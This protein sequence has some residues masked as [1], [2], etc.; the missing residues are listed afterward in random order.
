LVDTDPYL[1]GADA[2]SDAGMPDGALPD[3]ALPDGAPPTD[4]APPDAGD[5]SVDPTLPTRPGI[6][7]TPETP[8]TLD[9]LV[10]EITME[11]TD[12][13][14]TGPVTYEWAWSRDGA[15]VS[16]TGD[17]ISADLTSKAE[18]WRVGIT[19]V[20]SDGR[21]GPPGTLE[22]LIRNSLPQLAS[23]R[24]SSYRPVLGESLRAVAG[25]P[26]DADGDALGYTYAWYQNDVL[27][28]GATGASL[29][30]SMFGIASDDEIRVEVTVRDAE[31]DGNTVAVG[32]ALVLSDVTRWRQLLP[33]RT[34]DEPNIAFHDSLNERVIYVYNE[35]D[36]SDTRTGVWE[37]ALDGTDSWTQLF[38]S[39]APP[40]FFFPA[41]VEDVDNERILFF[42][43]GVL[44]ATPFRAPIFQLDVSTR[45][46]EAWTELPTIGTPPPRYLATYAL[47]RERNRIFM[48]GGADPTT[49]P[50]PTVLN[51]LWSLDI[52]TAG[53]EAWTRHDVGL[54]PE[55]IVGPGFVVDEARDRLMMISGGTW[56]GDGEPVASSTLFTLDL[57]DLST[58]FLAVS[59]TVSTPRYLGTGYV[60]V[61]R[62]RAL[63]ANGI[64]DDTPVES[65]IEVDL[66][67][68][69][70]TEVTPD[71]PTA[72]AVT[73][74]NGFFASSAA[75][76]L[77]YP[78]R[79]V[80][81]DAMRFAVYRVDPTSN[82][83]TGVHVTGVD[84]PGSAE[85]AMVSGRRELFLYGGRDVDRDALDT[86]WEID[87]LDARF[88]R[89]PTLADVADSMSP[90]PRFGHSFAL[91]SPFGSDDLYFMGGL[92][93]SGTR[94]TDNET[95][96]L[97]PD[98]GQWVHRLLAASSIRPPIA[99]GSAYYDPACGG[100][101]TGFFGGITDAGFS[102]QAYEFECGD[103]ERACEWNLVQ[104]QPGDSGYTPPPP[105]RAWATA[106]RLS[107]LTRVLLFGG[108]FG[109]TSLNDVHV[110]NPC[111]SSTQWQ[112]A[113]TTGT[114]PGER[115]GHS[116]VVAE[117]DFGSSEPER[118]LIFGGS[119]SSESLSDAFL[120]TV[121]GTAG[122]GTYR[123]SPVTPASGP[124]DDHISA[125]RHHAAYWD[126]NEQ[127]MVVYGGSQNGA[128]SDMWVLLLRP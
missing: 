34:A 39:G 114:P 45:G 59:A 91:S 3:G 13:M 120:L 84:L 46:A 16:E 64:A 121:E 107:D 14:A 79:G 24:L 18:R 113:S 86:L 48:Y 109:S 35:Q 56:D 124:N 60:D 103:G 70:L 119:T 49:E 51:E 116:A 81:D 78:G 40:T 22:V 15:A 108:R 1:G 38:P 101:L 50:I 73:G 77:Y 52:G 89:R 30:T 90:G 126:R 69:T 41:A 61:D 43:G 71:S 125:R 76:L 92:D 100:A 88:I 11:S 17:T 83:L 25:T 4:G 19:P 105:A 42:S 36:G 44:T 12:P 32:P 27:V 75:G 57:T 82:A 26:F 87:G 122:D 47:D 98:T 65:W 63:L 106:T 99:E 110:L 102:D 111:S 62:D 68:L 55:V 8:T 58:G 9:D 28:T 10:S 104:R 66:E 115:F 95:W 31:E 67:T 23:A 85:Q 117:Y 33:D 20:A 54:P 72:E 127:A 7:L 6:R 5:G 80:F 53:S 118:V 21:R 37:F 123:W 96:S 97:D 94:T 112:V 128:L 93:S 2:S 74:G 29:D